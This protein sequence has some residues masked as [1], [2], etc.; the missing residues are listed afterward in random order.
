VKLVMGGGALH[1][2]VSDYCPSLSP[3]SSGPSF[4]EVN[5]DSGFYSPA[6]VLTEVQHQTIGPIAQG[7]DVL[8]K[9]RTVRH[10]GWRHR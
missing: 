4:C 8:A 7:K 5:F 3:S 6:Q 1:S 10:S 9:A 2:T